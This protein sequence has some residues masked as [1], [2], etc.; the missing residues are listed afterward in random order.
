MAADLNA[1]GSP[2]TFA[3]HW[4]F[5]FRNPRSGNLSK[6]IYVTFSG[7]RLQLQC[8][9]PAS[10]AR[11]QAMNRHGRLSVITLAFAAVWSCT[12]PTNSSNRLLSVPMKL[13]LG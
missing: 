3:L 4:V 9:G 10:A 6:R 12:P 7:D 11:E 8:A 5:R 1:D 2:D 13:L